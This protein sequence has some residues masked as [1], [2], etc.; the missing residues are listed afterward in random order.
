MKCLFQWVRWEQWANLQFNTASTMVSHGFC[1]LRLDGWTTRRV[2]NWLNCWASEGMV[3]SCC[4]VLV[5]LKVLAEAAVMCIIFV[6]G[7][8]DRVNYYKL[9]NDTK[10]GSRA[11]RLSEPGDAQN[12]SGQGS[13]QPD[14]TLEG[15]PGEQGLNQMIYRD[16]CIIPHFYIFCA[17]STRCIYTMY[18]GSSVKEWSASS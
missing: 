11:G 16:P 10:L 13:K 1:V 18:Q 4:L 3:S 6:P 9:T 2:T 5:I 14:Q 12:L 15:S 17:R 7:Q 8:W